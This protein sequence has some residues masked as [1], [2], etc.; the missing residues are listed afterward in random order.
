MN[1]ICIANVSRFQKPAFQCLIISM[2]PESVRPTPM[3]YAMNVKTIA[4][5]KGFGSQ[6]CT[7]P[8]MLCPTLSTKPDLDSSVFSIWAHLSCGGNRVRM[9]DSCAAHNHGTPPFPHCVHL[10]NIGH[11]HKCVSKCG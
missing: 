8:A 9:P 10:K 5:R 3:T 1:T 11:L 6:D 7:F 4:N 2:G